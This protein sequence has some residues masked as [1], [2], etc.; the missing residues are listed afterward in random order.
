MQRGQ[1]GDRHYE[2]ERCGYARNDVARIARV[3]S[4]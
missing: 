3:G 1:D 2:H 4:A